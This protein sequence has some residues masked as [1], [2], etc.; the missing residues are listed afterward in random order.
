MKPV[1]FGPFIG[2]PF[3][4]IYNHRFGV[5]PHSCNGNDSVYG[6]LVFWNRAL[7]P[8]EIS[9][10][11]TTA[12]CKTGLV[13]IFRLDG[14]PRIYKRFVRMRKKEKRFLESCLNRY[15]LKSFHGDFFMDGTMG[16]IT[17][18]ENIC[19]NSF[20]F[21]ASSRVANPMVILGVLGGGV[22]VFSKL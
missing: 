13:A 22:F 18:W 1:Y 2:D 8:V 20:F 16:F 9:L 6:R 3:H 12:C 14:V 15:F 11:H 10:K 5:P 7:D 21:E 4:S 17:I 19:W